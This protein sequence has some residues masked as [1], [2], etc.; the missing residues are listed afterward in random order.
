MSDRHST[1]PPAPSASLARAAHE[2]TPVRD[3][4]SAALDALTAALNGDPAPH[5]RYAVLDAVD[6]LASD[7][8]PS[9][10]VQPLPAAP[11]AEPMSSP[12]WVAQAVQHLREASR[13]TRAIPELA[14]YGEA[15]A[16]LRRGLSASASGTP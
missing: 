7:G 12:V 15:A 4:I 11:S 8:A 2:H 16:T 9:T 3:P 14:R 10:L 1:P 13:A 6:S 5:L